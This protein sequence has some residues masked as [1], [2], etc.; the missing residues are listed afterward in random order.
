MQALRRQLEGM[1]V[2]YAPLDLNS[3]EL[4]TVESVI[5]QRLRDAP[6]PAPKFLDNVRMKK[7]SVEARNSVSFVWGNQLLGLDSEE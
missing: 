2:F 1:R 4:K 5:I 6:A 7:V 3:A